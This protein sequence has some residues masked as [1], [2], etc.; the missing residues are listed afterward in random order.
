MK[1]HCVFIELFISAVK[2]FDMDSFQ[3]T[4]AERYNKLSYGENKFVC[5]T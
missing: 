5:C 1:D 3:V 4:L 2:L